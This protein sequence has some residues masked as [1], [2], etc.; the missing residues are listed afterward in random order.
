MSSHLS[1]AVAPGVDITPDANDPL[2]VR[3]GEITRELLR[4]GIR[5]L[6]QTERDALR[7]ATRERLTVTEA[8][9]QLDVDPAIVQSSLRSGLLA[10]RQ[11][12]L[13]QLGES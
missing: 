7:L 2:V 8:A 13:N 5:G 6:S 9:A 12:L 11:A 10:L 1:I 4:E 3:R